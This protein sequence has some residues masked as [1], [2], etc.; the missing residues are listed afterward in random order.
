MQQR[1]AQA[2][3]LGLLQSALEAQGRGIHASRSVAIS[4]K[5][6]Q[7]SL[8]AKLAEGR[9]LEPG[10]LGVADTPLAAPPAPIESFE[11][12]HVVLGV[13]GDEELLAVAVDVAEGELC[14]WV[15]LFPPHHHAGALGPQS[16]IHQV[17]DLGHH[18]GVT[19]V[20][21]VGRNGRHPAL[22]REVDDQARQLGTEA[23][24]HDEAARRAHGRRRRSRGWPRPNRSGR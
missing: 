1:I 5:A 20:G 12:G 21:P 7:A 11:E 17:G 18:P 24:P 14:A 3:G 2:L 6:S 10:V 13:V 16:K 22:L 23:V 15:G 19:L 4:T 8:M 9:F